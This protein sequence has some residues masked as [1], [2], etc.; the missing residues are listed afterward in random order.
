MLA[1]QAALRAALQALC[2][3]ALWRV[4]IDRHECRPLARSLLR[5][6][7]LCDQRVEGVEGRLQHQGDSIPAG[8]VE[9]DARLCHLE[10]F[11][12]VPQKLPYLDRGRHSGDRLL[13]RWRLRAQRRGPAS[14]SAPKPA[15][16]PSCGSV[17][18]LHGPS[19]SSTQPHE[20]PHAGL[21]A[22]V[23]AGPLRWG[24]VGAA[25]ASLAT[26]S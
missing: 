17:Q 9:W 6:V 12:D 2:S 15:C 1:V 5:H 24:A 14:T 18:P 3:G 10:R 7:R 8:V 23:L 25:A 11:L 19:G 16:G 20:G 13:V 4:P 21:G 22:D 26:S